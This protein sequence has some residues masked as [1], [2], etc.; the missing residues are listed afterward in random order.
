MTPVDVSRVQRAARRGAKNADLTSSLGKE[1]V[2][3]GVE[4]DTVQGEI[5]ALNQ[6]LKELQ[7]R[8][9][10]LAEVEIPDLMHNAGFVAADGTGK[11]SLPSGKTVYLHNKLRAGCLAT[12]RP[13]LYAWLRENGHGDLVIDWVNPQ[14]L[15]SFCRELTDEGDE[16]PPMIST[17]YETSARLRAR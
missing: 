17:H 2:A 12:D 11:Y 15:E 6:Q 4:L 7:A 13:S 8:K 16:L 5:D 3:K 9:R 10:E 14:T 1:L